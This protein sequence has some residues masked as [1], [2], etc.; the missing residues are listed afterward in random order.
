MNLKPI[1]KAIAGL[2][3]G[4]LAVF[5]TKQ[6]ILITPELQDSIEIIIGAIITA[7]IVFVS[8]KNKEV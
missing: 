6:D 8:P 7:L 5:L 1:S 2:I 3:G 4:A